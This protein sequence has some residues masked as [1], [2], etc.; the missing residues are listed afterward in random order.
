MDK[1]FFSKIITGEI[2]EGPIEA[3]QTLGM[4]PETVLE[5]YL[6]NRNAILTLLR[7]YSNLSLSDVAIQLGISETELKEIEESD[8]PVS[9]QLVPKFAKV[10]N[11]DLKLILILL[12]HAKGEGAISEDRDYSELPLAAQYSGPE[13]TEQEK[14]DF[15]ELFKM[16]LEKIKNEDPESL[17][18][19]IEELI[20]SMVNMGVDRNLL[21]ERCLLTPT[22]GTG[23]LSVELSDR[24]FSVLAELKNKL[25]G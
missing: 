7:I 19:K 4:A 2:P 16:I 8:A 9:F 10:F 1:R 5:K 22:C 24:I 14:V 3:G 25:S 21:W 11:V 23:T 6:P 13:F 20:N 12:G 15:Q 17:A 18:Q